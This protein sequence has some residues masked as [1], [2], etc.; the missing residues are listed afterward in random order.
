LRSLAEEGTLPL[1][2][3]QQNGRDFPTLAGP[4]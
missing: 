3:P 2:S 4:P 1:S